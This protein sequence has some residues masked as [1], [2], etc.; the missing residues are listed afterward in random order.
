MLQKVQHAS[1]GGVLHGASPGWLMSWA[2]SFLLHSIQINSGIHLV[3]CAVVASGYF[4][5]G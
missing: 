4:P 1:S 5:V 2:G 3:P